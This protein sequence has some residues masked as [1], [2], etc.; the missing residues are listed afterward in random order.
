MGLFMCEDYG[1]FLSFSFSAAFSLCRKRKSG[2]RK[3]ERKNYLKISF[4]LSSTGSSRAAMSRPMGVQDRR[5]YSWTA[6][7]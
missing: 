1:P 5:R 6:S 4:A 2:K 7:S 3:N